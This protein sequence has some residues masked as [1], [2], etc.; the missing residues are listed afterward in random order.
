[1]KSNATFSGMADYRAKTSGVNNED[2]VDSEER[3]VGDYDI[4]RHV[5]MTGVSKY[6]TPHLTVTKVGHL[7][8]EWVNRVNG[9]VAD[10]V[11]TLTNDGSKSL[12]PLY[13]TDR[14]PVGTEYVSSSYKPTSVSATTAN[15]TI[16]HLGIGSSLTISLKLNVTEEVAGSIV[17][18]VSV[19]GIAGDS[20]ITANNYSTIASDMM[21]CCLSNSILL[22]KTGEVNSLDPTLVNF[23]IFVR[24]NGNSVMAVKLNDE[25]PAGMVFLKARS[26]PDRYDPSYISWV[27]PNLR[28]N[29]EVSIMYSVRAASNGAYTNKV[30]MEASAVD[31]SGEETA[32]ASAVVDVRGT[33]VAPT[34]LRYDGWQ[35]PDWD[36]NTS[37]QGLTI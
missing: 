16:L 20:I 36:L 12:A 18:R 13:V 24:N 33:G 22:D 30:H 3:Y 35:P 37:D 26:E 6:S 28:P 19:S 27:L 15:W 23:T 10:Y 8:N 29:E 17:N 9:T 32:D 31:G 4:S 1:M 5:T 7:K 25:L 11:I 34:T 14:F 2:Q 21:P